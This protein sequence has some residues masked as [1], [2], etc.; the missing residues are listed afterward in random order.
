M[1][2]PITA[3][4]TAARGQITE[5]TETRH[6]RDPGAAVTVID[7]RALAEYAMTQLPGSS[8]SLP[9][10]WNSNRRGPGIHLSHHRREL[11][12][13]APAVSCCRSRDR[14][15]LADVDLQ[16]IGADN[17]RFLAGGIMARSDDGLPSVAP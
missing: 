11:G 8:I 17:V 4:T 1:T 5:A 12:T 9:A 2:L 16:N 3:L 15:A 10:R 13:P 14:S 6:Y 7:A